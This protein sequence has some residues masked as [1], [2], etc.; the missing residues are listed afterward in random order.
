MEGIGALFVIIY[1]AVIV[2]MIASQWKVYS[3]AGKPGW[4]C[5]VPIYN[6]IVLLEIVKK[7]IWWIILF[8]IPIANIYAAIV[9]THRL[10]VSFGK[11]TGFTVGLLFLP[12]IF[13]PMLGFGDAEYNADLLED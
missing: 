9:M 8:M 11:S 12:I 4:A 1:L 10:S 13:I 7:P 6:L 2:L 5:L 3:K